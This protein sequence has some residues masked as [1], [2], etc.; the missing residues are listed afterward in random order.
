MAHLSVSLL[1]FASLTE[2][3]EKPS[4]RPLPMSNLICPHS[5][6]FQNICLQQK[7]VPKLI[8]R[9]CH[10][11]CMGLPFFFVFPSNLAFVD[12]FSHGS[13]SITNRDISLSVCSWRRRWWET[14]MVIINNNLVISVKKK[15][16]TEFNIVPLLL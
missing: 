13:C 11:F 7:E 9:L 14:L 2:T 3:T 10:L 6:K 12:F 16:R 4:V 15:L 8:S 5:L 1:E